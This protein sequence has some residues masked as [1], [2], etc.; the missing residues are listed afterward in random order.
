M[1]SSHDRLVSQRASGRT[2]R[3]VIAFWRTSLLMNM[4]ILHGKAGTGHHSSDW[5]F[6]WDAAYFSGQR[7]QNILKAKLH[8]ECNAESSSATTL[9]LANAGMVNTSLPTWTTLSTCRWTLTLTTHNMTLSEVVSS[10]YKQPAAGRVF[11]F[12]TYL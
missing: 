10:R 6:L 7:R 9:P 2:W 8:R 3:H 1:S 5:R 12:G 11:S 4:A